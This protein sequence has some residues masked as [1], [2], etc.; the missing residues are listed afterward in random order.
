MKAQRERILKEL[1][2]H[3]WDVIE[4]EDYELDWWT[5]EL[6]MLESTWSPIGRVAYVKFVIDPESV[7][8]RPRR[9][10]VAVWA[11]VASPYKKSEDEGF[12]MSLKQGWEKRLPDFFEHL[13]K[14]RNRV[15][16]EIC[17]VIKDPF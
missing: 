9:K 12:E 7:H 13:N 5:D 6:W 17:P 1:S 4:L 15:N 10:G 11:I 2:R 8:S 16:K 14:I 3:G